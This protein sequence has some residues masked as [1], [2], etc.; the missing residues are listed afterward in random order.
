M[1]PTSDEF[2]S[3]IKESVVE[4]NIRGVID[5]T[6]F[7]NEHILSG[8][9]SINLKCSDDNEINIGSVY[10]GEL[11]ITLLKDLT[12]YAM[13]GKTITIDCGVWTGELYEY[14][15]MGVYTIAEITKTQAG[16]TIK[17]YD[18][19]SLLDKPF[20]DQVQGTAFQIAT[21]I[22]TQCGLVLAND[23]FNSFVNFSQNLV[24]YPDS[25]IETYRDLIYWLAQTVGCFVVADRYGKI[26]FRK[27]D[28][29]VLDTLD[30]NNR[31]RD[32][33][34]ADYETWYTSIT[35]INI[36]EQT[37]SLYQNQTD[38]GLN[39]NLGANP[40]LQYNDYDTAR[41]N[42]LAAISSFRYVPFSV[43][44]V[45]NPA[46]ELGDILSFPN[47]LGDGSK[48]FCITQITWRHGNSIAISGSGKN[49][50]LASVKGK[51]EKQLDS[52]AKRKSDKDTIQY[53]AF[54]NTEDITIADGS[55]EKIIDIL[56]TAVKTT[57]AIFL[58]EILCEIE[59]TVSGINYYDGVAEFYCY[60]DNE[61]ITRV[62]VETWADGDHIKHI[63]DYL[64]TTAGTAHRLQIRCKMSGGSALIPMGGIKAC[65]Y[66]QNLV[67][68]DDWSGHLDIEEDV[69]D[70]DLEDIEF[71]NAIDIQLEPDEDTQNHVLKIKGVE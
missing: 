14:I 38:D 69:S 28:T 16:V 2:Q 30:T 27:Y 54:T 3:A 25:D 39:Y 45:A 37:E 51:T 11:N 65:I 46:Y 42:V 50:K 18:N 23:D 71:E 68:S 31:F 19:M 56:Y 44:S 53:Y 62:P 32:G 59:T 48:L 21:F 1:F 26:E 20:S 34:F 49:P 52:I 40:F 15:P 60:I 12:H 70:W 61:L 43:S 67:A 24:L 17:A 35:V 47:G 29:T 36:E 33:S 57:V 58:A 4:Y 10:I 41:R 64:T 22:C 63:L 8:S 7:S 55:T 5:G 66:G 9:C 6:V 13:V